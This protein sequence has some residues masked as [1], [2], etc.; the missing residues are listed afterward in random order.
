MRGA[1]SHPQQQCS[2]SPWLQRGSWRSLRRGR[3]SSRRS[4]AR[5]K[6]CFA[7]Q[8]T[9]TCNFGAACAF[10][11]DACAVT[12]AAPF[13]PAKAPTHPCRACHAIDHDLATCPVLADFTRVQA[14]MVRVAAAQ[15]RFARGQRDREGCAGGSVGAK[16]AILYKEEWDKKF[17]FVMS[18]FAVPFELHGQRRRFLLRAL[19]ED[20]KLLP[21][22][23]RV[24]PS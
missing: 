22:S 13:A 17:A 19:G 24:D 7:F 1:A 16:M 4:S 3:S 12:L 15:R 23:A 18:V 5:V 9:G 14:V 10:S 20:T 11:H 21:V 2:P 8:R 6:V